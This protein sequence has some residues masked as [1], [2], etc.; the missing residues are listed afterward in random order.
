V[1]LRNEMC[2]VKVYSADKSTFTYDIHTYDTANAGG[3]EV[4]VKWKKSLPMT[5]DAE[6]N[7]L[8]GF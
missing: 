3:P 6:S 8:A 1:G 5:T 7:S 2:I 4:P